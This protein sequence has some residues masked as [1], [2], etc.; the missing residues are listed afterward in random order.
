MDEIGEGLK[1]NDKRCVQE[2]ERKEKKKY[3]IE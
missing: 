2:V 1:R 3:A